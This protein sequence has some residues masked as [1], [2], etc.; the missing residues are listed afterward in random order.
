MGRGLFIFFWKINSR[1]EQNKSKKNT[2]LFIFSNSSFFTILYITLF[3]VFISF[4]PFF[5][6]FLFPYFIFLNSMLYLLFFVWTLLLKIPEF[7]GLAVHMM[8]IRKYKPFNNV[9]SLFNY[10]SPSS[11]GT[12][13]NLQWSIS[14]CSKLLIIHMQPETRAFEQLFFISSKINFH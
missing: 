14:R 2:D 3:F 5:V 7:W 4:F 10:C 11:F 8:F 12:S 1:H 13:V 6:L 9:G